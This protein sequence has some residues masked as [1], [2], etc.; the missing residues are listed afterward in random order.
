MSDERNGD[1]DAAAS[2]AR[3]K[4][5]EQLEA[6][7]RAGGV[8]IPPFKLARLQKQIEDK[9]SPEYQRQAW[10]ALRKSINGLVNKANV[11]NVRA[12]VE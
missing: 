3:K 8:Y 11:S 9:T 1:G 4:K 5:V 6:L 10:E 12:L 2:A 7:G